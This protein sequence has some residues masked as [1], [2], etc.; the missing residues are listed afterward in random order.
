MAYLAESPA[1]ALLEKLVHVNRPEELTGFDWRV[2]PVDIEARHAEQ[3]AEADLPSGWD[4]WPWPAATQRLSSRWFE[5][6]ES[7]VL[8][9]PSAVVCRQR[10]PLLNPTHPQFDALDVGE[11]EPFPIDRRPITVNR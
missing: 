3:L 9:I 11:P 5:Q 6:E 2:V 7:A 10:N 4:A 8:E 1:L